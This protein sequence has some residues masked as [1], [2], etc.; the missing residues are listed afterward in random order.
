MVSL[1]KIEINIKFS[2]NINLKIFKNITFDCYKLFI[3]DSFR[4]TLT[5]MDP[6]QYELL[7]KNKSIKEDNIV[8]IIKTKTNKIN[9]IYIGNI[10]GRFV[11]MDKIIFDQLKNLNNHLVKITN[12]KSKISEILFTKSLKRNMWI[13]APSSKSYEELENI[14]NLN[15]KPSDT[16]I[17]IYGQ[18]NNFI[19]G[20]NLKNDI[21]QHGKEFNF[22]SLIEIPNLKLPEPIIKN[23][24]NEKNFCFI[25]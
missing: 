6:K 24:T 16:I 17:D 22:G 10:K 21:F 4:N 12:E 2:E 5:I 14:T 20:Y 23:N 25:C 15:L 1:E 7:L 18:V 3:S 13:L 19:T 9:G 8:E 11:L